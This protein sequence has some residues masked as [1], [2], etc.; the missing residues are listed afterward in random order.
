MGVLRIGG[1]IENV[2]LSWIARSL[3][4]VWDGFSEQAKFF[5]TPTPIRSLFCTDKTE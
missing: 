3:V 2:V 4:G 5:D 1:A